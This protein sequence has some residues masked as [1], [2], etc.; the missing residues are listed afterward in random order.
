MVGTIWQ[1]FGRFYTGLFFT[2]VVLGPHFGLLGVAVV[3]VT[4]LD[5]LWLWAHLTS[6][7]VYFL[8]ENFVVGL[9]FT[10]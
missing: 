7:P 10:S 9:S 6:R 5:A 3:T 1:V 2:F 8:K 4:L